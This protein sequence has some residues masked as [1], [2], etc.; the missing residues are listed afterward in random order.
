[1]PALLT[2][3]DLTRTYTMGDVQVHALRGISLE[4]AEGEFI[5][6]MGT[7]GSGKSTLLNLLGCLDRPTAGRYLLAGE[8]VAK[9]SKNQL[10]DVRNKRIGFVF[11]SF[12]LLS[13]TSASWF[14]DFFA[15]S[16]PASR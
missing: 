12:N 3:E 1:M 8:D 13:R 6:I 5:A 7:S 14:L 11:Q 15:T 4:I 16:S 9:K 10:A 2:L